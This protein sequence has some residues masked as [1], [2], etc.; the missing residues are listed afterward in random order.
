MF[1][2][3][4]DIPRTLRHGDIIVSRAMRQLDGSYIVQVDDL[5]LIPTKFLS[6]HFEVVWFIKP[7]V[8]IYDIIAAD[9]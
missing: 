6:D 5:K 8:G 3:S 1:A 4:I 9:M 2:Q 7:Q